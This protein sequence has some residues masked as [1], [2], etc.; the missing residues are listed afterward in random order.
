[1]RLVEL[2]RAPLI[3]ACTFM[4][5][6]SCALS[7]PLQI[8][9]KILRGQIKMTN[10]SRLT[11]KSSISTRGHLEI[12]QGRRLDNSDDD[13]YAPLKLCS[14]AL[15]EGTVPGDQALLASGLSVVI[16]S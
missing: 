3:R 2:L 6:N 9:T 12:G 13:K 14:V 5:A 8:Q 1:M 4:F 11:K 15:V 7:P 10:N 16:P